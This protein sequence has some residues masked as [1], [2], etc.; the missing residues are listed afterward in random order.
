[1]DRIAITANNLRP[2]PA[3]FIDGLRRALEQ[4]GAETRLDDEAARLAGQEPA[5]CDELAAWATLVTVVGGD[6]SMLR[7]IH[8]FRGAACP[9]LG[10][11]SG[12]LGY[13]TFSAATDPAETAGRIVAKQFTVCERRL[14]EA[15]VLR[16]G[17]AVDSVEALNEITVA[18]RNISR[19]IHIEAR[20]GDEV[21]NTYHADGLIVATPT[22]STAYSMAAGGPVVAPDSR[23]LLVTPICPHALNVRSLVVADTAPVELHLLASGDDE[24]AMMTNDGENPV[25]IEVGD[26]IRIG[27]TKRTVRLA[28]PEGFSYFGRLREKLRWQGSNI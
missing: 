15:G 27:P 17:V 2:P 22:G 9:I 11:N 7:A 4:Q 26:I 18:R 24:P 25:K 23:V 1:M 6:G 28:M 13:L 16:D 19:M 10:V 8:R 5:D 12:R 21:I 14:L 20:L 3:G